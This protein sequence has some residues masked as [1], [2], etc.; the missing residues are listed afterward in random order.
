[1]LRE[2]SSQSTELT[3]EGHSTCVFQMRTTV[4]PKDKML[5]E[6][7]NISDTV[8]KC[9]SVLERW[10][11]QTVSIFGRVLLMKMDSLSGVIYPVFSLPISSRMTKMVNT[12]NFRLIWRN[13]CQY[14]LKK[15]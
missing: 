6:K 11:Q 8:D 4:I 9:K 7:L 13:R 12:I 15:T 10:L 1:M 5:T 14:K 2:V 3:P